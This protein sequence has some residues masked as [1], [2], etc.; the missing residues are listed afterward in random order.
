MERKLWRLSFKRHVDLSCQYRTPCVPCL[1]RHG[2][3]RKRERERGEYDTELEKETRTTNDQEMISCY[4]G[5]STIIW[6][7]G[8]WATERTGLV[9]SWE[10]DSVRRL[11]LLF[12][13]RTRIVFNF[14]LEAVRPGQK[15][16]ERQRDSFTG[17]QFRVLHCCW[18]GTCAS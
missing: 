13:S 15:E 2:G 8:K 14:N 11:L 16:R 1:G 3:E 4:S 18:A 10:R 17:H 6:D 12:D 5:L 7:V 9:W